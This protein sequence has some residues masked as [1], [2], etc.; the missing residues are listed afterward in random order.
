MKLKKIEIEL[1]DDGT[2]QVECY[3]ENN[4]MIYCGKRLTYSAKNIDEALSKIGDAKKEFEGMK[5]EKKK[6]EG[7]KD[8][9]KEF[10]DGEED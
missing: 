4:E 9:V 3:P 6:P 1:N 2:F 7:K 10:M 5:V 8:V